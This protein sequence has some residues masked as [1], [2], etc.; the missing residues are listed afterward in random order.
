MNISTSIRKLTVLFIGLFVALSGVFVYWQV[1]VADTVVA[2]PINQRS[3]LPDSAP[4]RGNIY[5]RNG[6]LLATSIADANAPCGYIRHYTDPSLAGLIGYYV[7]GYAVTGIENQY[8]NYLNGDV[9]S[10]AVSNL[11]NKTLHQPA[12]GNNIYLTID[13]RIQKIVANDFNTP[14][15]IDNVGTFRTDRGSVV[16]T[17]PKTGD[18]LAILSEPSFDPNKMVQ[19]LSANDLSYYNQLVS[20]TVEQ[21][22]LER[23]LDAL[24]PPGSIYK[25]VTLLAGLD[26]RQYDA[27]SRV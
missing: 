17:D 12:V 19:T 10:T 21:P 5:D 26:S 22:L 4:H 16:V 13:E 27:Q 11:V 1:I 20:E 8:N 7:P 23:P 9:G 15:N 2:N 3:C 24:Y 6:V 25:S 14:V 18:V